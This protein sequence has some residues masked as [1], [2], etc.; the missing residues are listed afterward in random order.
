M[1][2]WIDSLGIVEISCAKLSGMGLL[3][4]LVPSAAILLCK[5]WIDYSYCWLVL[6]ENVNFKGEFADNI[7]GSGIYVY[8]CFYWL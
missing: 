4:F 6:L 3:V 2:Y 1:F 5:V 7:I 8:N